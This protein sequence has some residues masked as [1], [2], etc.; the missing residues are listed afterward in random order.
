MDAKIHTIIPYTSRVLEAQVIEYLKHFPVVAITGPRQSGKSTMLQQLLSQKYQYVSLDD[1]SLISLFQEDPKEFMRRYNNYIIFDEVQKLPAL[2]DWIKLMVDQDRQ[3]YGKFILTGSSQ[4]KLL[5]TI[6]E[7][8]AG[9][10]GFL[11]LLPFQYSELPEAA[12]ELAV[13]KGC[14]P[15]VVNRYYHFSESW[16]SAYLESYIEKD[17]RN[18]YNLGDLHDFRRLIQLL[19]ANTSQIL[20]LSHYAN[21][22][23]VAVNTIKRWITVLQASYIIFLLPPFYQNLGKRISKRPKIY[24]Y[25][26]GI[27]A[28][29]TGIETKRH[30]ENGPMTGALFENYIISEIYKNECHR[31]SNAQLYY[32]RT[33]NGLEVDLIIDR[34]Q[35][36]ELIEIKYNSTFKV[37]MIQ[38]LKKLRQENDRCALIYNG[39]NDHFDDVVIS[40]YG[41]WLLEDKLK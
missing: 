17:V 7:S 41:D 1:Q 6:S 34:K 3:Q 28:Y 9:R 26:T 16:Y 36:K 27:V 25:D 18:L 4:L 12:R 31:K 13:Y 29:L 38:A 32:Y 39:K 35:Y 5:E 11:T 20:D 33:S 40:N 8:L 2:F 37:K 22:I 30:F 23:G 10:I 21:Q 15:E 14:Y 24:F 19:A